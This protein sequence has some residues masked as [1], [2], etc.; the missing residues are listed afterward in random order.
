MTNS[1]YKNTIVI[2]YPGG[3][4]GSFLH[5]V[6]E[7]FS[8]NLPEGSRPFTATG[9]AHK[10]QGLLLDFPGS[11]TTEDYLCGDQEF[12]FGRTHGLAGGVF[13]LDRHKGFVATYLP[14]FKKF[15]CITQDSSCH[16]MILHNALTKMKT[17]NYVK[18][19]DETIKQYASQ[20]NA[21]LPVPNWQLREML[22]YK[23]G[24]YMHFTTGC[25]QPVVHEKVINISVSE[26]VY[27]FQTTIRKLFMDLN[28]QLTRDAELSKVESEWLS[29]QKF[30]T[31]DNLCKKIIDSIIT[32]QPMSWDSSQLTVLDEAYIQYLL[33]INGFEIQCFELDT[34]PTNSVNLK[35][36]LY[37]I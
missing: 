12:Q 15:V 34:F 5:W 1:S 17:F 23:H 10:F 33:R 27:N 14:F 37:P 35:E 13:D 29:C 11:P 9:S 31:L 21:T 7:Y 20:F 28:I 2:F 25:F 24:S 36:L 8:G 6:L 16:L 4:Y 26:L 19:F 22:S 18:F 32:D 30:T 3:G